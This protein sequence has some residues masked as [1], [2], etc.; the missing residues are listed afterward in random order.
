MIWVFRCLAWLIIWGVRLTLW[1]AMLGLIASTILVF[2]PESSGPQC[3]WFFWALGLFQP[4][5]RVALTQ[6]L[7]LAAAVA[8]CAS[9]L[10]E[11]VALAAVHS[12]LIRGCARQAWSLG[13]VTTPSVAALGLRNLLGELS[14]EG[15]FAEAQL[16]LLELIL[17]QLPWSVA[18]VGILVSR[19]VR[20]IDLRWT[21]SALLAG[22]RLGIARA[23]RLLIRPIVRA[24]AARACSLVFLVTIT[25]PTAALVLGVPS[26]LA[27]QTVRLVTEGG[28][29]P[30]VAVLSLAALG[31][32]LLGFALIRVVG[33]V[34]ADHRPPA[35]AVVNAYNCTVMA[36]P[37]RPLAIA[38]GCLALCLT[39]VIVLA[40]LAGLLAILLRSYPQ[41]HAESDA[42]RALIPWLR[43]GLTQGAA[44][45]SLAMVLA[46]A[47]SLGSRREVGLWSSRGVP[48]VPAGML[49]AAVVVSLS[50]LAKFTRFP[51]MLGLDRDLILVLVL[52]LCSFPLAVPLIRRGLPRNRSTLHDV[53]RMAG[54]KGLR[55]IWLVEGRTLVPRILGGLLG[56]IWMTGLDAHASLILTSSSDFLAPGPGL[57]FTASS[58][59]G[60]VLGAV[61]GAG[62][63]LSGMVLRWMCVPAGWPGILDGLEAGPDAS[64][65]SLSEF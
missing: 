38:L 41:F 36:R 35:S 26:N 53:A 34:R 27:A 25:E 30:L 48:I 60:P 1:G 31:I 6:S 55:R 14:L 56:L 23:S 19:R 2:S 59:S 17:S 3:T 62:I 9:V 63:V 57:I 11:T 22:G 64:R 46:L 28:S 50:N 18:L 15:R 29:A 42:W 39:L 44:A 21:D 49:A 5:F 32:G 20:R 47:W 33:G 52:A 37:R 65:A 58:S 24:E 61:L 54:V 45:G 43:H 13:L 16:S 51:P 7:V 10:G 4:Q 8:L 40:P 12:R